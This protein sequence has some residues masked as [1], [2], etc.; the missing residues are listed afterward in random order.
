MIDLYRLTLLPGIAAYLHAEIIAAIQPHLGK[1]GPVGLIQ[2]ACGIANRLL[3][4]LPLMACTGIV[5]QAGIR[6]Q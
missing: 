3:V 4:H 6:H 1:A 5:E 2:K